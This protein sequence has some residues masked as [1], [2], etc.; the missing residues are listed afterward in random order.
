MD[1]SFHVFFHGGAG[2]R[3]DLVVLDSDGAGG[4]LVEA[5]VNDTKGL[6]ELFHAA[7]VAIVAVS[8]H[9]DGH[10]EFH[11]VVGVVRL[12]LAYVPRDAAASEHDAREGVVE[13]VGGGNDAD[14]LGSPFPD[15]VVGE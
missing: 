4:H 5:L 7:E 9:P 14:V 2:R 8:V 10:V 6:A 1:E 13:G 3:G 15:P 12:A 11:L